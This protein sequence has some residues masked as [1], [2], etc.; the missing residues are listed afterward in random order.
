MSFSLRVGVLFLVC[1]AV[2]TASTQE[3]LVRFNQ[4]DSTARE[5]FLRRNGGTLA[6]VSAEG[7]LFKWVSDQ[8]RDL[9]WDSNIRFIQKNHTYHLFESPSLTALRT[10]LK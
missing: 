5:E 3:Y 6:E 9:S 7:G 4:S 1:A 2:A 8:S 10:T